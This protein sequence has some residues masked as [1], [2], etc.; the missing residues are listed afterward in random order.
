MCTISAILNFFNFDD[1]TLFYFFSTLAQSFAALT[2]FF[3]AAAQVRIAWI[4]EKI[5]NDKK[6]TLYCFPQYSL[7]QVDAEMCKNSATDVVKMGRDQNINGSKQ[8][9]DKLDSWIQEMQNLRKGV[10]NFVIIGISQTGVG[11]I[12]ILFS[13]YISNNYSI[14]LA[15]FMIILPALIF[16]L[17]FMGDFIYKSL[18]VS[19]KNN[20]Y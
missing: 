1:T 5:T 17:Y 6:A 11:I 4:D 16:S 9:A 7:N 2:A 8:I 18:E 12:G 10:R 19:L 3:F 13:K 14:G 20:V 15:V